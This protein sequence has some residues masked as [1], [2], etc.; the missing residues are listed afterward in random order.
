MTLAFRRS[1]KRN[2]RRPL[3][4]TVFL[5]VASLFL[6]RA[7]AP[8]PVPKLHKSVLRSPVVTTD[9]LLARDAS[10]LL[11]VNN[12]MEGLVEWVPSS[13]VR[14]ALAS[15]WKPTPDLKT[16]DFLLR[17]SVVFQSGRPLTA[18]TV[19][20]SLRRLLEEPGAHQRY[21]AMVENIEAVDAS[22]IRF[23]LSRPTPELP[24]LLAC[25]RAKIA[26]FDGEMYVGTGPFEV[27]NLRP[28]LVLERFDRYWGTPAQIQQLEFQIASP[29]WARAL[30][31]QNL[32]DDLAAYSTSLT[33]WISESGTWQTQAQWS[34]WVWAFNQRSPIFL[35]AECRREVSAWIGGV[36]F[37]DLFFADLLPASDFFPSIESY[38]LPAR[39]KVPGK[40]SLCRGPLT[41]LTT[42][43]AGPET[44]LAAWL[45]QRLPRTQVTVSRLSA[46]E[47]RTRAFIGQADAYLLP[48]TSEIADPSF[49]TDSLLELVSPLVA[50]LLMQKISPIAQ[51]LSHSDSEAQRLFLG[52]QVNRLLQ[53]EL[54]FVP[55]AHARLRVWHRACVKNLQ[56]NPLSVG[57]TSYH[58]VENECQ[59]ASQPLIG[60]QAGLLPR[61]FR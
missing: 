20:A 29:P 26:Y 28:G 55:I 41:V 14:P 45:Q 1:S 7:L 16:F 61:L 47:I 37:R 31:E 48:V 4:G 54:A 18:G 40:A 56:T 32:V 24:M 39:A 51:K 17:G 8:G 58:S 60:S 43:E 9:P 19:V 2:F 5:A 33:P 21:F 38:R 30:A 44:R 13:G 10:S 25:S 42:E 57:H 12:T 52:A 49:L 23:H 3:L 11:V 15:H 50:P 34:T 46:E 59:R 22:T 53:S 27:K 6:F 36:E 35:S